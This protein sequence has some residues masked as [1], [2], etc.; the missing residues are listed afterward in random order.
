[1]NKKKK[2]TFMRMDGY[3]EMKPT[4]ETSSGNHIK[5]FIFNYFP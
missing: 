4:N 2:Q 3:N 5:G 1:M